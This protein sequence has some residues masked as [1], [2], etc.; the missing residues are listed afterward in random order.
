MGI[1]LFQRLD[2]A[3]AL[4]IVLKPAMICHQV[5]EC[6]LAFVAKRGMAEVMREGDGLG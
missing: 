3:Q 1:F 5:V 6:M 4:A 2:N